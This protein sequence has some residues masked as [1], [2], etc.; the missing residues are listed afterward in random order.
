VSPEPLHLVTGATGFTGQELV[1]TLCA[2]GAR[3][4]AIARHPARTEGLAGLPVDWVFGDVFD[5]HTVRRAME[6]V[7]HVLHVAAVY[8]VAGVPDQEYHRVHVDST[9]LLAEAALTTPGFQRFVH[10][11]T[12]GVHG[13]IEHPPANEEYRYAPGDAYQRTKLEGEL[14]LR[15]IGEERG[16]PW[17]VI[18]PAAIYGPGDRRLLKIFRFARRRFYP[19]LGR[20]RCLYHLVHVRDLVQ[21]LLLAATHP[22]AAG[23]VFLCGDRESTSLFEMVRLIAAELG[24]SPRPLRLPLWPFYAAA[25]ACETVCRPL[26]WE[27]PLYRRRVDFYTKDRAFD[28]GK[29]HRRLGFSCQYTPETGLRECARWYRE[30]GWL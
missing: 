23:Q 18:R 4:R 28:T 24:T 10:V 27:P 30:H 2:R 3:V 14:L 17:S 20:G 9:R 19:V 1:R 22:D 11:S 5:P 16:L 29:I 12:M 26:G 15:R 8:R 6:G 25:A 7:T 21:G 13:H